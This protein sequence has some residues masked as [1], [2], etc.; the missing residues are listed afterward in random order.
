LV[1]SELK[2]GKPALPGLSGELA[3]LCS[4]WRVR[5]GSVDAD[6]TGKKLSSGLVA[7]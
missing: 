1:Y 6:K 7:S 3:E 5:M 4:G 2:L